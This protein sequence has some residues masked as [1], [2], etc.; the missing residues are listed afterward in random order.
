MT[1]QEE[2]ALRSGQAVAVVDRIGARIAQVR[3]PAL[4]DWFLPSSPFRPTLPPE[5]AA[6]ADFE[7]GARAGWDECFPSVQRT[8]GDDDHGALWHRRWELLAATADRTHLLLDDPSLPV[9]AEREVVLRPDGVVST[10]TVANRGAEP[11]RYV[12]SAHPMFAWAG[13]AEIDVAGA[14]A[15]HPAFGSGPA[16]TR[17]PDGARLR[18]ADAGPR[19]CFKYFL[20]WGGEAVLHLGGG[21]LSIAADP[22]ELP[23]LGIC[24]NRRA[25]PEPARDQ[26]WIA[27]EPCTAPTDSSAASAVVLAPGAERRFRVGV[28]EI[29]TP[30]ATPRA[31]IK[32]E[33]HV[34]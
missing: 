11:I 1:G 10:L 32:E 28:A 15:I 7:R 20:R 29:P 13:P 25:W 27:V 22:A 2:V 8:A 23:W 31:T 33:S 30:R 34:R 14:A 24:V 18:L 12:Y 5:P 21:A 9:R 17:R 3:T 19:S 26:Q 4:G 6:P 16:W